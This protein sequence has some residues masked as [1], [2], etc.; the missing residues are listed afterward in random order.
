MK[1]PVALVLGVALALG[2]AAAYADALLF[3]VPLV[4]G[5]SGTRPNAGPQPARIQ[6]L[7]NPQY[8]TPDR[9]PIAVG[10]G[11]PDETGRIGPTVQVERG[12]D[13]KLLPTHHPR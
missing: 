5:P 10:P 13:G 4:P 2:S 7:P 8:R 1:A 11:E 3:T 6:P 9:P 12:P